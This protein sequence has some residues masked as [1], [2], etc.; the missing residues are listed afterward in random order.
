[1]DI[2][3]IIVRALIALIGLPFATVRWTK[4]TSFGTIGMKSASICTMMR[5]VLEVEGATPVST[6]PLHMSLQGGTVGGCVGGFAP[7]VPG[8]SS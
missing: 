1:M 3:T 4:G 6:D 2:L 5:E 7:A 8:P